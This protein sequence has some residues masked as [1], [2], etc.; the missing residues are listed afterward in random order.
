MHF[1]ENL[2]D[3]IA[4]ATLLANG[5]TVTYQDV[6]GD[7]VTVKF[8]KPI[9]ADQADA[10]NV[11]IFDSG[12]VDGSNAAPQQLQ[13]INLA[14]LAGTALS[15][16]VKIS[17]TVRK[18]SRLADFQVSGYVSI[19][20]IRDIEISRR[21]SASR[22]PLRKSTSIM[23]MRRCRRLGKLSV[24]SFGL[25]GS[26]AQ[27]TADFLSRIYGDVK[28]IIYQKRPSVWLFHHQRRCFKDRRWAEISS[29]GM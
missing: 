18:A 27:A 15:N 3:R 22:R 8:S 20:T 6:D 21:T 25:Y 2:E 24:S 13:E 14:M 23:R 4:P 16:G 7:S 5:S 26:S 1:L 29:V 11:F 17:V 12:G 19:G 9:F 28:E 10:D